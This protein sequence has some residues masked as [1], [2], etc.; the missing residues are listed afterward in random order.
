MKKKTKNQEMIQQLMDEGDYAP[1]YP[2]IS[3]SKLTD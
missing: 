1:L 2:F 3:Q